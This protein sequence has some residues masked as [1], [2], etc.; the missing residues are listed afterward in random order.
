MR[1]PSVVESWGSSTQERAVAD[2]CDILIKHPDGELFRGVDV[3]VPPGLVFRW[4][5]QL[6][7]APYSYD[8]IDNRGRRSPPQLIEGLDQLEVGQRFMS[9]FRLV[10]F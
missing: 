5:C 2:P 8:W 1:W 7:V 6:R 4:L 10:A 9:I 3:S